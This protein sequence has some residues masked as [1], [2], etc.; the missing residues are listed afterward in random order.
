MSKIEPVVR[1]FKDYDAY[2]KKQTGSSVTTR[3]HPVYQGRALTDFNKMKAFWPPKCEVLDAGCGD[4]YTMDLMK[5]D[6][7]LPRGIDLSEAKASIAR[8]FGHAVEVT[9][10][11][12]M[13]WDSG[14][15]DVV[16]SRHTFEHILKPLEVLA[17]FFRVLKPGGR[18]SLIVPIIKEDRVSGKH[19]HL[20]PGM[21]YVQGM[22]SQAGFD[23]LRA[24]VEK[25]SYGPEVWVW[26]RKP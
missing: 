23:V 9:D 15:F 22:I 10:M 19:P 16:Y 6:G 4:G 18:L 1:R 2:V 3:V 11:S 12:K 5:D 14:S 7:F 17:E 24:A 26:G 13:P 20:I 25:Q 8:E 21:E